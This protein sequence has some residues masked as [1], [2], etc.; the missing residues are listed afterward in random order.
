MTN[1]VAAILTTRS[2]DQLLELFDDII[3]TELTFGDTFG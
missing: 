1:S 3:Q 2:N